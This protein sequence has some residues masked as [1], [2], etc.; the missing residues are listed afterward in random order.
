M[1]LHRKH[2]LGMCPGVAEQHPMIDVFLAFWDFSKLIEKSM[3]K[4]EKSMGTLISVVA[5]HLTLPTVNTCFPS[6]IIASICCHL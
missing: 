4:I 2:P 1:C 6:P 5:A 3:G